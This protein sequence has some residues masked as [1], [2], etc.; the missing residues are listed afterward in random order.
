[1][2]KRPQCGLLTDM[3]EMKWDMWVMGKTLTNQLGL[4]WVPW[5]PYN[6]DQ[7]W[8]RNSPS[9]PTESSYQC[10]TLLALSSLLLL[11]W[12][13]SFGGSPLITDIG[14]LGLATTSVGHTHLL[15]MFT[16]MAVVDFSL[17]LISLL[18]P[19][20]SLFLF[21]HSH[22]S[23]FHFSPHSSGKQEEDRFIAQRDS[24]RSSCQS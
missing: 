18:P 7:W 19:P 13:P 11:L 4:W 3:S 1:M 24:S 6:G 9:V 12:A 14:L 23:S 16:V 22:T 17:F 8:S 21:N 15:R 2:A 20:I 5:F 10:L